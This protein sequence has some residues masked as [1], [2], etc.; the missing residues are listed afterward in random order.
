M[1]YAKGKK[2]GLLGATARGILVFLQVYI[3]RGGFLD[4]PVGF[5]MAVM[6]SQVAFN[7]YAG[8]WALRRQDQ[9]SSKQLPAD[10][11]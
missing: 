7:K 4:G 10:K 6:Y 8:L 9:M 1:R 3:L 11:G 2:G 5:I